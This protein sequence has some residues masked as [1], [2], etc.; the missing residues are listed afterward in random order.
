MQIPKNKKFWI[1]TII[2]LLILFGNS[3]MRNIIKQKKELNRLNK[4]HAQL[5]IDNRNA[6]EYLRRLENDPEFLKSV[7]RKRLGLI[8]PGETIY[9]FVDKE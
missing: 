4:K 7:V 6:R 3:G 8:E 9:R 1:I 5:E 2:L